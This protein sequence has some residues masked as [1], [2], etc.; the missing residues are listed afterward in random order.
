MKLVDI[1]YPVHASWFAEQGYRLDP[2]P[3]ISEKLAVRKF[4]A[5]L[6]RLDSLGDVA[7]D[8]F[9]AGRATRSYTNDKENG[10][11]FLGSA[12]IFQSDLSFV[13][14]I[15]K[16]SS[17]DTPRAR[18]KPGWTLI[19]RSGMTAGRVTY[20]RLEMDGCV[21]S[22]DVLR[23]VPD[24]SK[25]PAGYLYTFLASQ[26]GI[27]LIRG[28]IYGTSVKHIEPSHIVGLPVPRVDPTIEQNI[29]VLIQEAMEL[30]YRFQT[31]IVAATVDLFKSAG[32]PE[33][34][35]LRWHEQPR[36]IGFT[37]T[38]VTATSLRALNYIPRAR[39]IID[40]IKSVP[41]RTLGD[42]CAQGL[43]GRGVSFKR[44]DSDSKHGIKLIGQRQ[45]F[46][47]KPYG[48]WIARAEAGAVT[49]PNETVLLAARGTLGESEVYCRPIFVTHR[50]T[51]Y[52][53]SGD[54]L[55]ISSGLTDFPNAFLF[56]FLRSEAAF[57]MLRA[58]SSGSKQQDLHEHLRREIPVPEC[59]PADRERI[60][61]A[62]R[63]AYRLREEADAKEDQAFALL[64]DAV[65]EAAR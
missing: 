18:L 32:L 53:Y 40:R 42:I 57:R 61:E 13:P 37:V 49:V 56:A 44:I 10:L 4:L 31:G 41:H 29:H 52:A 47:V 17:L 38:G 65:R 51:E 24:Q 19:T 46:W 3:Y 50:W 15:A 33:L 14:R 62:V 9:H 64:T 28:G 22:E 5:R 30:R 39:R 54:F 34:L 8:I 45:G 16:G 27:P 21:C 48:R 36:D 25:I 55:R 35:D 1:D 23:V 6:P 58:T 2:G 12:D 59:T 60:A 26:F 43:L 63:D 11:P 20:S 7:E